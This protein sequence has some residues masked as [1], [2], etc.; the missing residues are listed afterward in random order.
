MLENLAHTVGI[1]YLSGIVFV[2]HKVDIGTTELV[3]V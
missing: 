2:K 1:K 3:T